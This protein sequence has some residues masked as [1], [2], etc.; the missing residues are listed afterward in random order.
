MIDAEYVFQ[1]LY[2]LLLLPCRGADLQ[3]SDLRR[4]LT[5]LRLRC[6]GGKTIPLSKKTTL[7]ERFFLAENFF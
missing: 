7:E 6:F 5:A 1:S 4:G 2:K 3:L